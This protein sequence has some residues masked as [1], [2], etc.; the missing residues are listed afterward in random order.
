MQSGVCFNLHN[1]ICYSLST[2][3]LNFHYSLPCNKYYVSWSNANSISFI[4]SYTFSIDG[5]MCFLSEFFA[6]SE[7][8]N[9]T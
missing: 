2:I 5:K 1:A 3:R 7:N 4:L 6:K 8:P 9:N